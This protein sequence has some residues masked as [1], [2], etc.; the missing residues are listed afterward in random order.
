MWSRSIM[1]LIKFLSAPRNNGTLHI[2]N[3]AMLLA[4][5]LCKYLIAIFPPF[6]EGG[7]R[8]PLKNWISSSVK[9]Y[10]CLSTGLCTFR[11]QTRVI[12][13]TQRRDL[14]HSCVYR[15]NTAGKK[16][17]LHPCF[18]SGTHPHTHTCTHT[19]FI[20]HAFADKWPKWH[21][22]PFQSVR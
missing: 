2:K 20:L 19:P 6:R 3:T 11:T 1:L 7:L 16:A 15:I 4:T 9:L 18:Q 8:H 17:S 12:S 13:T 21:L 5:W 14:H 22:D 10:Q